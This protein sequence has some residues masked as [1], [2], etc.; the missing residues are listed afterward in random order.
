MDIYKP[1]MPIIR[2]I[3][4]ALHCPVTNHA[5]HCNGAMLLGLFY[6]F[7]MTVNDMLAGGQY[8]E[9][10]YTLKK[11]P[12][13]IK[14]ADGYICMGNWMGMVLC[15]KE[16]MDE[17]GENAAGETTETN[18]N[19]AIKALEVVIPLSGNIPEKRNNVLK[20]LNSDEKDTWGN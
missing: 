1:T 20:L 11:P 5:L 6:G 14:R 2:H 7:K 8:T 3:R 13:F 9:F 4:T 17:I 15:N 19:E 12:T 16:L 10:I 18:Y